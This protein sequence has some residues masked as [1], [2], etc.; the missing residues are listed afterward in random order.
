ML[1]VNT[2]KCSNYRQRNVHVPECITLDA[3]NIDAFKW[4]PESCAYRR[5]NENRGLADWHPLV[6]GSDASVHEAG[7]SV[8]PFA[9]TESYIHPDDFPS[10][11]IDLEGD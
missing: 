10:L 6:S 3:N 8:A 4:L 9:I 7:I 11:V 5:L 2:C 1:D